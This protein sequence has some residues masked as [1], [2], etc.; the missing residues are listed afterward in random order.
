MKTYVVYLT[1]MEN[2]PEVEILSVTTSKKIADEK[3]KVAMEREEE[4][5][6][7]VEEDSGDWAQASM[8]ELYT[9][10][11]ITEGKEAFVVV[12]NEWCDEVTT[13]ICP[14]PSKSEAKWWVDS[15]KKNLTE[16]DDRIEPYDEDDTIEES[17]HLRNPY[18][19]IDYYFSI[20]PVIVE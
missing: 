5:I 9:P 17:M 3:F 4:W 11:G 6:A 1:T 16:S 14:F 2:S 15:W 13:S 20:V 19:M 18:I 8:I 12:M 7:D 10:P